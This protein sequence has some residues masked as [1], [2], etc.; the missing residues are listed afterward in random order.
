MHVVHQC[1]GRAQRKTPK[2]NNEIAPSKPHLPSVPKEAI[3][4]E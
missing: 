3:A 1:L 2:S 4:A